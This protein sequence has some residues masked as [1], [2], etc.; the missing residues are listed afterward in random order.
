[1][2]CSDQISNLTTE[3][4]KNPM[5]I[6]KMSASYNN[7]QSKIS[8]QTSSNQDQSNSETVALDLT[9]PGQTI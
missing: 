9:L 6:H 8:F 1:M 7:L 3:T 5:K 2:T 4:L